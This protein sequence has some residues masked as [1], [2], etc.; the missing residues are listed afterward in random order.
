MV[1]TQPTLCYAPDMPVHLDLLK[2]VDPGEWD[3]PGYAI[4]EQQVRDHLGPELFFS[5]T[6]PDRIGVVPDWDT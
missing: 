5:R 4:V 1:S 2:N 3:T 6:D